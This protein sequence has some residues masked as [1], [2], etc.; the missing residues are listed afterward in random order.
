MLSDLY[1]PFSI[2]GL[3]EIISLKLTK[4]FYPILKYQDIHFAFSYPVFQML[5]ELAYFKK[6]QLFTTRPDLTFSTN[7]FE[8][9]WVEMQIGSPCNMLMWCDLPA[10][11][12]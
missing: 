5:E 2:V 7:D 8:T 3:T 6:D 9:L 1:L 12:W 11:T 10:S 4:V